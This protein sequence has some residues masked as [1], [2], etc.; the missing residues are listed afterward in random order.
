[1]AAQVLNVGDVAPDF[2]LQDQNRNEVKLS[3]LRG[4]KVVLSW[5]PLAWTGTCTA[6]MKDLEAHRQDY[7]DRGA[8]A[9]GLS[10]DSAPS[11]KAWAEDMGVENTTLLADFWPHGEVAKKYGILDEQSGA[12]KRAV[13]I[14]DEKGVVRWKKIYPGGERPDVDEILHAV[15]QV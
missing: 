1:L 9:L 6:Q 15:E 14:I 3:D 4:K 10:V 2:T 5:H 8:V 7:A 11:K 12:S 13:F